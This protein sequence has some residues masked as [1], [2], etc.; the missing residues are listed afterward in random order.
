MNWKISK[1]TLTLVVPSLKDL[2]GIANL[3]IPPK[4][5]NLLLTFS[6][7]AIFGQLS[8]I[9]IDTLIFCR[10]LYVH[11]QTYSL[12]RFTIATTMFSRSETALIT[13]ITPNSGRQRNFK[14]TYNGVDSIKYSENFSSVLEFVFCIYILVS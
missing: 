9:S 8:P 11:E 13:S 14:S 2:L 5:T 1:I 6:F 10:I 7:A 4:S 12:E 3:L